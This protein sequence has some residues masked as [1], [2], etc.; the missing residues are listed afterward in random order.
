MRIVVIKKL[1]KGM[2]SPSFSMI[3]RKNRLF[4]DDDFVYQIFCVGIGKVFE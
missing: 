2:F 1:G 3:T 4:V